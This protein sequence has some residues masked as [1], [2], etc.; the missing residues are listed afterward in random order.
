L[1]PG[2]TG[3]MKNKNCF[4]LVALVALISSACASQ[5]QTLQPATPA[6]VEAADLS[7]V[8]PMH[9]DVVEMEMSDSGPAGPTYMAKSHDYIPTGTIRNARYSGVS[10]DNDS[11]TAKK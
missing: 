2:K 10:L 1:T 6:T 4:V 7:A 5:K 8:V 11:R 9:S 3:K